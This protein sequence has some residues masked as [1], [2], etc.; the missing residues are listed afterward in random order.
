MYCIG[1][2]P[3]KEQIAVTG[4]GDNCT[5]I[6]DTATLTQL[7]VFKGGLIIYKIDHTDSVVFAKFNRDGRNLATGSL[8]N[9]ILLYGS[10][11]KNQFSLR[12]RFS[13][14]SEEILFLEWHPLGEVVVA[15]GKDSLIWVINGISGQAMHT[16]SGHSQQVS[17]GGFCNNS[18]FIYCCSTDNTIRLWNIPKSQSKVIRPPPNSVKGGL[19]CCHHHLK[20][21]IIIAGSTEG[22]LL[23]V[24]SKT[25]KVN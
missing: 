1:L 16:L 19:N 6:W 4:D 13:Q 7:Q 3:K 20:I 24:H 18:K 8:D 17:S 25:L 23:F 14:I 22:S 5:I 15:G 12:E 11:S 21:P 9:C 2:N 10:N